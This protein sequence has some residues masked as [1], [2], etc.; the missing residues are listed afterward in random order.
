MTLTDRHMDELRRELWQDLPEESAR[1]AAMFDTDGPGVAAAAGRAIAFNDKRTIV[2]IGEA[3]IARGMLRYKP[4]RR[5]RFSGALLH[6]LVGAGRYAT[7]LES[8]DALTE[9]YEPWEAAWEIRVRSLAGLN[10]LKEARLILRAVL[11][12]DPKEPDARR[13]LDA[14]DTERQ[15]T[16]L[17]GSGEGGWP[18]LR[19]LVEAYLELELPRP[20]AK[21]IRSHLTGLR[22]PEEADYED[23]LAVLKA[24]L[25]LMG[26]EFVLRQAA[27]LSPSAQ[28][29]RLRALV[30]QS[31][32]AFGSADEALGPDE[33]GR[34]L[35]LQR[36]LAAAAA[37]DLDEAIG[38]LGLLSQ[39]LRH[40][41]EVREALAYLTGVH[42][43]DETPLE[44]RAPGGPRRIFNLMP[45]N[46]ELLLLKMHLA[47]MADW[48]DLFVIVES[49]V[50][51]TGAPKPLHFHE[52][53][54]EFAPWA[55]KIRH[56]VVPE[57]PP[58]FHSPWG[59]DFRQR[60]LAIG[61]ISGLAAPDDLVLLTDVDEI[62]D[63][64]ALEGFD[65]EFACLRM[66]MFRFF[67]NYRPS[68]GNRP[69]RRT[70]AVWKARS[71]QRF[72]SSYARFALA[73]VK[74]SPMI[75]DAGWHLTSMCD[76][77]RLVA[78]VNS[79]A[80]QERQAEWRDVDEVDRR[81][82][83]I[84]SGQFEPGWERADLEALPAYVREH[85]DETQ[86]FL[87]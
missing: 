2:A 83:E 36:A 12:R 19:R 66:A 59:R 58:A 87:V 40:D 17:L 8:A 15:M 53:R 65:A 32:I 84:R 39:R 18:D 46:D 25:P 79:Y 57:H 30:A 29:D 37:G 7:A 75:E 13:M 86:D 81:L 77:E 54:H 45:F 34:D 6:A 63:R 69:T 10:R 44:L 26:P 31:L 20:A 16:G 56:V 4:L 47:E 22:A 78:K 80:H 1:W 28:D 68:T 61:A 76:P 82:A 9:G 72:G 42:V 74:N 64:R 49:E 52:N 38:R 41:L 60:D 51:F 35:R 71:L 27:R 48:V 73:R 55:D 23:A 43:L 33:G 67:L 24:A 21:A 3:A 50:T 11:A 5:V 70:G 14:I 85:L 62:I